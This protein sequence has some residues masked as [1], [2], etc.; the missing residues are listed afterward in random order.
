MHACHISLIHILNQ[1][2]DYSSVAFDIMI[3]FM[4]LKY[5][6]QPCVCNSAKVQLIKK[7]ILL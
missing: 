1:S 6:K 4:L 7:R 3:A 5:K 2:N